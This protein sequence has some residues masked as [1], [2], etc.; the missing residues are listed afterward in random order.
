V[1]LDPTG[2]TPLDGIDLV[3]GTARLLRVLQ[4]NILLD[5]GLSAEQAGS[6]ILASYQ[7]EMPV[8]DYR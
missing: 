5:I 1:H 2:P 6:L 4:T 8:V 7:R 3:Y